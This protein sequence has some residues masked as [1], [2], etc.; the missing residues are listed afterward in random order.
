MLFSMQNGFD[1]EEA[2]KEGIIAPSYGVDDEY[3]SVLDNIK[4][5]QKE[6]DKYL[7]EQEKYF[8]CRITYFGT[9]RKRY[10]LEIPESNAKRADERYTVEGQ[11]KAG[12]K[13]VKR[14]YTDETRVSLYQGISPKCCL[15]LNT[16]KTLQRTRNF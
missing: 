7:K 12:S 15:I 6:L 10:Q 1:H 9:D 16:K 2:L 14:F 11:R 5:I 3:D 13:S 4:S 8:G